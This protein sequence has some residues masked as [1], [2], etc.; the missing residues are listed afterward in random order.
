M[1][2]ILDK[3]FLSLFNDNLSVNSGV[4]LDY[5]KYMNFVNVVYTTVVFSHIK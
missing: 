5:F 3:N 4:K 1:R 2:E